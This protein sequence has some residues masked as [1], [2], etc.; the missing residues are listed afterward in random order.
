MRKTFLF[1]FM[2][3]LLSIVSLGCQSQSERPAGSIKEGRSSIETKN[4][5]TSET[6]SSNSESAD[7]LTINQSTIPTL[8]IHGYE[9]TE[10]TF[11]GMLSRLEASDLG[12]KVLTVTV[13]PDG[14][15][16]ETGSWQDQGINPL[17]Q[18]LF[19]DNK[20]NEWNQADWIKAVL[21]Y[22]KETHQID[23][24]NLVGHSMGGVSSFRYL[25]TYGNEDT[26]PTVNKFIAIGAPFNDFVTGNE[27]QTLDALSQNG[28]SVISD[29]YGD[30]SA[31]IQ[32]YPSSTKMLNIVGNLQ[33]GSEGDGTVPV[34]SGLAIGYLMQT[35]G[36]DYHVEEIEGAQAHHSQ[37]H[38]NVNVDKLVAEFLWG[39]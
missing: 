30:F 20:N 26:L 33:D 38:E 4:P 5:S 23:E 13:Q 6:V 21:S 11:N 15:V 32:Q 25:V 18:V 24:V 34:R 19:A 35:N 29:R 28:P 37:L 3:A 14:S 12:E 1:T 31:A 2:V 9:G 16:S 17:I 8:F 27:T 7:P 22:L 39:S 10:G 36:L